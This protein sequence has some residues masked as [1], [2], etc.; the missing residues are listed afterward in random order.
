MKSGESKGKKP[1]GPSIALYHA[2]LA[3]LGLKD[4]GQGN[5][6]KATVKIYDFDAREEISAERD[7]F[8]QLVGKPFKVF[9]QSEEYRRQQGKNAG[10]IG[11]SYNIKQFYNT[12]SQTAAEISLGHDAQDYL[13][14]EKIW[15]DKV[16][17]ENPA[18]NTESVPN[19]PADFDDDIDFS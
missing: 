10:S 3:I 8:P 2:L 4:E 7:A 9:L 6:Q 13:M 19:M 16:L 18:T 5:P 11:T 17:K 15:Q 12:K 1:I 14:A